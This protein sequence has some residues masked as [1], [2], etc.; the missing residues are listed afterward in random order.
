MVSCLMTLSSNRTHLDKEV[1]S[2]AEV[3]D[4]DVE[5]VLLSLGQQL[6]Q[7]E[8][9]GGRRQQR[10]VLDVAV[11]EDGRAL[12]GVERPAVWSVES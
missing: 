5:V 12:S 9:L 10:R 11:R 2:G 8:D 1:L 4:V 3:H 6:A 7:L